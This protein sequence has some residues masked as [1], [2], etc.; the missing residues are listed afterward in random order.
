MLVAWLC[1]V[2][3][4]II[5]SGRMIPIFRNCFYCTK[6]KKLLHKE[7]ALLVVWRHCFWQVCSTKFRY[8]KLSLQIVFKNCCALGTDLTEFQ[9]YFK[10]KHRSYL[11]HER[12]WLENFTGTQ[13]KKSRE[14]WEDKFGQ[15]DTDHKGRGNTGLTP[16]PQCALMAWKTGILPFIFTKFKIGSNKK[17]N[18]CDIS[19][20]FL[21]QF[22]SY[23]ALQHTIIYVWVC[24][25]PVCCKFE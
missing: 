5:S 8:Q 16:Y 22:V 12:D 20:Y 13:I 14:I 3:W 10:K 19:S 23:I 11:R 1:D 4:H 9:K 25:N 6:K 18:N 24:I 2:F 7:K 21:F 15:H 17:K